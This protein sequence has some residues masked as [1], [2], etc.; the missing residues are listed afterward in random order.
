M[1]T[2]LITLFLAL[3]TIN[4]QAQTL[5]DTCSGPSIEHHHPK[6]EIRDKQRPKAMHKKDFKMMCEIIKEASY[7][8]HQLGINKV[9]CISSYFNSKQCVKLLTML[10]FDAAQLE[11]LEILAPR[12][13]DINPKEIQKLFILASD[14]EKVMDILYPD[15]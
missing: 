12:L 5:I 7:Y 13:V 9:A 8:K 3:C 10:S 4:T 6:K 14:K 11:A 2:K 1:R 15:K